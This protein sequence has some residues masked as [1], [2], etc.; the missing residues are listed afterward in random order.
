M[1]DEEKAWALVDKLYGLVGE[2][3]DAAKGLAAS[4]P[5]SAHRLNELSQ[6]ALNFVSAANQ[7]IETIEW[8]DG[9]EGGDGG[10]IE[11]EPL[12][13]EP[14]PRRPKPKEVSDT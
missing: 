10:D 6:A 5:G 13:V 8:V 2:C 4:E 3:A 7:V 12:I 1:M 11:P 14:K 9:G